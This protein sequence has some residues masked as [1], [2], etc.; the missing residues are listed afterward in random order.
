MRHV[1]AQAKPLDAENKGNKMLRNMGWAP[2]TGLGVSRCVGVWSRLCT[3]MLAS[4]CPALV[5]S[6]VC[7]VPD[8]HARVCRPC[9]CEHALGV[10]SVHQ[11]Q[12]RTNTWVCVRAS[13][14]AAQV[15]HRGP[16]HGHH[17]PPQPR[18]GPHH[19]VKIRGRVYTHILTYMQRF[20]RAY[21]YAQRVFSAS[22]RPYS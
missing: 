19:F 18:P 3:H 22:I 17:P 5:P 14:F 1:G 6:C 20:I 8:T 2:G 11:A 7:S 12:I 21:A 13:A 10:L 15:G 4:L 16:D 9:I